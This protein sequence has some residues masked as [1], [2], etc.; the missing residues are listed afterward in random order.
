MEPLLDGAL[1]VSPYP[2]VDKCIVE[3]KEKASSARP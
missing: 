2:D 1:G 3:V